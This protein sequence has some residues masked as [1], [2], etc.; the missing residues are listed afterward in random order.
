M[1]TT[2]KPAQQP[3]VGVALDGRKIVSLFVLRL[4]SPIQQ[5]TAMIVI[6]ENLN[7]TQCFAFLMIKSVSNAVLCNAQENI[8]DENAN[9]CLLLLQ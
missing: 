8:L 1:A 2:P 4:Q 5:K 9:F 7:A 3:P 6:L